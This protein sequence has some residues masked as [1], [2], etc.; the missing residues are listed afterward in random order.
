MTEKS[1][2]IIIAMGSNIDQEAHIEQAKALLCSHFRDLRFSSPLWTEPI[3]L[4]GSDKFLNMVAVGYAPVSDGKAQASD[5]KAQASDGKAQV[6][7]GKT[8]AY[9]G[10]TQVETILKEI[11]DRCGRIRG[12]RAKNE[13]LKDD[14]SKEMVARDLV[15]KEMVARNLVAMDL[16]LLLYGDEVCHS[17]DWERD[18]IKKSLSELGIS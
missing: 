15:V 2:K 6:Y 11:E 10:K 5:G 13:A 4:P 1:I 9:E 7:E 16:D 14:E 18:Y 12:E 3:G 8:Q 17:R